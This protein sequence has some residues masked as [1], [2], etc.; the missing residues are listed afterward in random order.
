[1]C[2]IFLL[3]RIDVIQVQTEQSG[4]ILIDA[5]HGQPHYIIETTRDRLHPYQAYPLLNAIGSSLVIRFEMIDIE[6]NLAI[7][8]FFEFHVGRHRESALLAVR[9][10][11]YT[12]YYMMSL[13]AYLAQHAAGVLTVMGFAKNILPYH[14]YRVSRNEKFVMGY[15]VCRRLLRSDVFC[16]ILRRQV[17]RIRLVNAFHHPHFKIKSKL[18]E[19]FLSTGR[20]ACQYY[21]HLFISYV[22]KCRKR[23]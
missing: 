9:S 22:L 21:F 12:G 19:Q 5:L 4:Q 15:R 13:A 20:I 7:C 23:K 14:Y 18:I 11:A 2:H 10:Y 1:M 8:E 3:L 6:I 16:H 17:F